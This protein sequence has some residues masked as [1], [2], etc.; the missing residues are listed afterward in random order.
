MLIYDR[1]KRN[2][3]SFTGSEMRSVTSSEI[4]IYMKPITYGFIIDISY[5]V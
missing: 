4:P 1:L 5:G 3:P 2:E